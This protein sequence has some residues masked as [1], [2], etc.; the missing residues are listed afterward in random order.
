M[1]KDLH[2]K[3]IKNELAESRTIWS[4][5]ESLYHIGGYALVD[6]EPSP[7]QCT[8]SFSGQYGEYEVTL[9]EVQGADGEDHIESTCTC[10]YPKRGC[11]HTVAAY[12]DLSR[13]IK[14]TL[15]P[16]YR[17]VEDQIQGSEEHDTEL[18]EVLTPEEVRQTAVDARITRSYEELMKLKKGERFKGQHTVLGKKG[19]E[20]I[21]TIYDSESIQG[22]CT[23]ADYAS[24]HLGLCKH[25]IYTHRALRKTRGGLLESADKPFP[26]IHLTWN[27]LLRKPV[28][29]YD[30]IEDK[31]LQAEIESIFTSPTRVELPY[32]IP[33]D[34]TGK[35]KRVDTLRASQRFGVYTQESTLPLYRLWETY[36]ENVE[37][38]VLIF[39]D[40][41][42]DT[43]RELFTEKELSEKSEHAHVDLSFLKLEPYPYQKE[44]ITFAAF[45]PSTVI[46]DEMGLGKTLQAIAVAVEKKRLFGFT[47]TLIVCPASLKSQW[48]QEIERFTDET[49]LVISGAKEERRG[50]YLF[51]EAFFKITNYEAL[52][53]D[54]T[55]VDQWSPDFVI[56]DEAQRIKNFETKTHQAINAIPRIHSLVI[57]G[58]PLENKLE[59]LYSIMQ[60]CAPGLLTPLWAFAATHYRI[61]REK[62]HKIVGYRNLDIIHEKLTGVLLRRTKKEVFDSLPEITQNTYTL[63]LHPKQAQIHRGYASGLMQIITKKFITPVDLLMMQKILLSMRMVCD[64]TFLVD[65]K[66]NHSPKLAELASIIDEEVVANG[67][68]AVIFTEWTQMEHLI[69]RELEN[70]GIRFIE[71][72]SRIPV[73]KRQSLID[74]FR[75]D[76][77]CLIFLSTDAGG[78][79]LNLQNCDLLINVELPW[80]PARLNQRI[81]RIH[82]IGQKSSKV[83]VI[84]LV[85]RD[86]IE[87]R[88]QA[89]IAM[90]QELFNAVFTGSADHVDFSREEQ[91]RFLNQ[92]REMFSEEALHSEGQDSPLV[93][94]D[95]MYEQEEDTSDLQNQESSPV[96]DDL[97]AVDIEAEEPESEVMQELPEDTPGDTSHAAVNE[98]IEDVTDEGPP[99]IED[100]K[101]EAVLNQG[102]T[103]LNTLTMATTGKALFSGES[104]GN[105]IQIDREK[106]EVV[107]RFKL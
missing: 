39:D 72:N 52:M 47:K 45:R 49:N 3:H 13:R 22:H 102:L 28:C 34:T 79:G 83:N 107:L 23:C 38:S 60:F 84:N 12:L 26:F 14:N 31:A 98:S 90:K 96:P 11:K 24:N 33:P 64:S 75:D 82:R 59:D 73:E 92:I 100:E 1:N 32:E 80:N 67:R 4:R 105:H 35:R 27:S 58:T 19:R 21:V 17:S 41:L 7:M 16:E 2:I 46:A 54:I 78:V 86:S 51:S 55:T 87:E 91:N 37:G 20:Y 29:L 71:F 103:F 70:R 99:R 42:V 74:R 61:S 101:L 95:W 106:G 93:D 6:Y 77:E 40:H 10:P 5:G 88:I 18:L 57:T 66:T 43:M 104:E 50:Q 97:P 9:K 69:A 53:R 68:K 30:Y 62:K 63:P 8:Y 85:S 44:G 76:P 81:G 48:A 25:L 56:L 36:L 15:F 89:G 65:R 94:S